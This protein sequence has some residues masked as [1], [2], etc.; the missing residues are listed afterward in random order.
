MDLRETLPATHATL[1]LSA[2]PCTTTQLTDHSIQSLQFVESTLPGSHSV[3]NDLESVQH[4]S[5]SEVQL[6]DSRR[7]GILMVEIPSALVGHLPEQ[8]ESTSSVAE[9]AR[10]AAKNKPS[11]DDITKI[12]YQGHEYT[13]RAA[14]GVKITY[15]CSFYRKPTWYTGKMFF[16]SNTMEFDYQNIEPHTCSSRFTPQQ[17]LIPGESVCRRLYDEM[18][19]FVDELAQTDMGP[20]RIWDFVFQK[21][22]MDTPGPVR[23]LSIKQVT[24]RVNNARSA[25]KGQGISAQVEAPKKS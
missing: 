1:S 10:V 2:Q 11:R 23:G 18:K 6:E 17:S 15:T 3:S 24:T 5:F 20:S 21:F 8:V 13:K 4:A 19:V 9:A 12:Y 14:S 25:D 22:Y 16:Y 7:T